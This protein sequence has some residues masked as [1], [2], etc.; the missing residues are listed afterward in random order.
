MVRVWT[1]FTEL[2]PEKQIAMFL[3]LNEVAFYAASELEEEVIKWQRQSQVNN[4]LSKL[5]L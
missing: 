2:S 4:G 1:K 3:S 5:T